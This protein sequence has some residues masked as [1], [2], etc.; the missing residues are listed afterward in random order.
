VGYLGKVTYEISADLDL[1]TPAYIMEI[2]LRKLSQ[3]YGKSRR[4]QPLPKFAEEKRDFAFVM[5]KE[6]TCAQVENLIRESCAYVTG[7]KLFDVYEGIQL[8]PSKKSMAFNVVFTP[9]ETEFT[10]EMI[11]G[12]VKGILQA[13]KEKYEITLRV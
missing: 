1:R 13:L 11:D 9:Q 12:F 5:D 6:I 4:F 8:A 3:W 2:D 10:P 7:V